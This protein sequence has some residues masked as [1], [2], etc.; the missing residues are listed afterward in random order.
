MVSIKKSIRLQII[1]AS[2]L[3]VGMVLAF[4]SM[5]HYYKGLE[6]DLRTLQISISHSE[7][8][9]LDVRRHEKDFISRVD[10]R[11]ID[12]TQQQ[13][14]ELKTLILNID[15]YLT[16]YQFDYPFSTSELLQAIDNYSATF[17][18]LAH[19]KILI[20]GQDKKG[21]IEEFKNAWFELEKNILSTGDKRYH[22]TILEL[23]ESAYYFFRTFDPAQLA[24]TQDLIFRLSF[25]SASDQEN[26]KNAI[27]TYQQGF[28]QLQQAYQVF[29]YNH[30]SG[31]HGDL[32]REIHSLESKLDIMHQRIP[33][34]I[35]IKLGSIDE[36]THFILLILFVG[37]VA[38][39]SY[40]TWS[41]ARLEKRLV[42]SES[43]ANVSN[44]AKSAFLA[45]MS[46]EIRTP[47]N[48]I[49]G[50]SQIM[51]DTTLTPNQRD[52]LNAIE[53]S[54]QTLLMLINDV[55]DLSKIE[56]GH[57]E[58]I[59]YPC[60]VRDAIYDTASMVAQKI[61]EK[62]IALEINIADDTPYNVKLDEHRLRQ[63][64][65][66]LVSNAVKFTERGKVSLEVRSQFQQGKT[67]LTFTVVDSGI[68]IEKDKQSD[69]FEPFK[70]E[71]GSITRQFG[72]T[73]LGL[74]ISTQ[75]VELMGG[76]L[77]LDSEKGK[78]SR[79]YFTLP[80][81]LLERMPRKQNNIA[82]HICVIS[83]NEIIAQSLERTLVFYGVDKTTT[84]KDVTHAVPSDVMFLYYKTTDQVLS[85]L[86]QLHKLA[87]STPIIIIQDLATID[88]DF[89]DKVDGLIKYPILG[90]RVLNTIQQSKEALYERKLH[91]SDPL[92]KTEHTK[93]LT[94]DKVL[95]VEDNTVN[96]LVVSL[97][98]KKADYQYEIANNGLEAL[99]KIKQGQ[100]Y[101]IMLMD[102]M[103]P[104]MD[105]FTATRE[106]RKYE[107]Q[108]NLPSTPIVALTASVLDQDIKK[109]T[110][111]GMDD[112][113][114][115]PLKKD[116]LY[117][118]IE[119]YV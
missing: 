99:N 37:L 2:I 35:Q 17:V 34:Q 74:S 86:E 97:F 48:G 33:E 8:M 105:G 89:K 75:L 103:M 29:G 15:Q 109:C 98:L 27:I 5:N 38:I 24:K 102:C 22:A 45:N 112:Y 113:L 83:T 79:F 69:I 115:K 85:D 61:K 70:Q 90:V 77:K 59:P 55:L 28:S 66:N 56:S 73:G 117:T 53:T 101:Q 106:I 54:S 46:H 13:I 32:R 11:Y 40:A 80:V 93:K 65:M 9:V 119:K 20:E 41:I 39:L 81:E 26:V 67:I 116:K 118:M 25:L 57:I 3:I 110:E 16:R 95:I 82:N 19:Q 107:Q 60:H 72:G 68:G 64:L 7:S 14:A 1:I 84:V 104:E 88:F 49:I 100:R 78:G 62:N 44:K 30:N 43:Q 12:N 94:Q 31:L 71:D 91:Q 42:S 92:P 87:P 114:S 6:E 50:M 58:I 36:K 47:L 96:Q 21:L 23:Q 10:N 108:N 111:V 52:Y 4:A 63:I 18:Q 51:T 76:K